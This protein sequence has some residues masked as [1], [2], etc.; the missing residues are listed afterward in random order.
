MLS[1]LTR[2]TLEK[3]NTEVCIYVYCFNYSQ[4]IIVDNTLSK[5][6]NLK[7]LHI[8]GMCRGDGDDDQQVALYRCY[9]QIWV[10]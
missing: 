9:H 3:C 5:L 1:T 10:I 2:L 6:K 7:E 8:N 4:E